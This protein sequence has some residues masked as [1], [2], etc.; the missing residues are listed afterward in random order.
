MIF[1]VTITASG[2]GHMEAW[3][4]HFTLEWLTFS[5]SPL[6]N[7][8]WWRLQL[9]EWLNHRVY[10]LDLNFYFHCEFSDVSLNVQNNWRLRDTKYTWIVSPYC[11]FSNDVLNFQTH[12]SLQ[13]TLSTW[14]ASRQYEFSRAALNAMNDGS[15]MDT[16]DNWMAFHR[17]E[18]ACG[19][20]N[21]QNE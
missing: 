11:E 12:W 21:V 20:L 5:L 8:K 6:C 14:K 2:P 1:Q 15:L 9:L 16:F 19:A 10:A 4:T 7:H 18:F 3:G 13:S 17:C